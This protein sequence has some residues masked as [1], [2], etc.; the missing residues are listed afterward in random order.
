MRRRDTKKERAATQPV[1]I[2]PTDTLLHALGV[3]E[4]HQVRLLPVVGRSGML[5]GLLS[6]AHVLSAWG[7]NPLAPVGAVMAV[8]GW[9]WPRWGRKRRESARAESAP[10]GWLTPARG[11]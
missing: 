5:L 10:V 9:R 11:F 7:D 2:L 8:A 1:T 6:E 4:R 3:M